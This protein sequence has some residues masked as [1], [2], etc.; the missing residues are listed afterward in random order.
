MSRE[1]VR[2]RRPNAYVTLVAAILERSRRGMIR[3]TR[4]VG[5][6]RRVQL[7]LFWLAVQHVP[8]EAPTGWFRRIGH[9]AYD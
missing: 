5:K 7:R 8:T 1:R 6:G 9:D 3:Q 4:G 2:V